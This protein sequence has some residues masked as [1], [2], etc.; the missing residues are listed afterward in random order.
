ME[1]RTGWLPA[2]DPAEGV[3]P[4]P[5]GIKQAFRLVGV[6]MPLGWWVCVCLHPGVESGFSLPS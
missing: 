1:H 5:F 6:R 4:R 2:S 3:R